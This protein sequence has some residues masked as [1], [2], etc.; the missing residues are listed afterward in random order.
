MPRLAEQ[1]YQDCSEL[2]ADP[3]VLAYCILAGV[4][5][6]AVAG[7]WGLRIRV[8]L[9][10]VAYFDFRAI[11]RQSQ[12]QAIIDLVVISTLLLASLGLL[13]YAFSVLRRSRGTSQSQVSLLRY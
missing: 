2:P 3:K 12:A 13:P 6:L 5:A 1:R 8:L 10:G 7:T 11:I 9:A 4:P